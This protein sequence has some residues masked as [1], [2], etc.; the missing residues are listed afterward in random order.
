M[1]VHT[2]YLAEWLG[3]LALGMD[4]SHL[5]LA[6]FWL[7]KDLSCMVR[8]EQAYLDGFSFFI[9]SSF[10]LFNGSGLKCGPLTGER[11]R[12]VMHDTHSYQQAV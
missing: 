6:F 1:I 7:R 2:Q 5:N 3:T 11:D 8:R 9:L 12:Q 10:C 4:P